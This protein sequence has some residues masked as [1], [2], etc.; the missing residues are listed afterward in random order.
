M[1]QALIDEATLN[2]LTG[3]AQ[4]LYVATP[5]IILIFSMNYGS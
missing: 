2:E 5:P 3:L 1:A 4:A